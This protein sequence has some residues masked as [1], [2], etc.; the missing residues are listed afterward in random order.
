MQKIGFIGLGIMG[1]P[2]AANLVKAGY[3]VTGFD[4]SELSL[5]RLQEAGGTV[6]T[7][8]AAATRDADVVIT[9]LPDSPDVEAVVLGP[10]GVLDAASE[11][12]LLVDMSTI[13]P[14]TSQA[15]TKAAEAKRVRVLDAPV[16]GG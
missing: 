15:V 14:T 7:S 3:Q 4:R 10:D 2:M 6:A 1:G 9:M 12:L 8:I 13:A 16:S 5:D 11:G